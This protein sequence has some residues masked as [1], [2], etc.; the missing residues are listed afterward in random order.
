MNRM[1]FVIMALLPFFFT[2]SA[3]AQPAFSEGFWEITVTMEIQGLD[4]GLSRP[5]VYRRCLT[6]KDP[7]PREPERDQHCRLLRSGLE[8]EALT[9]SVQCGMERGS[10]TGKGRAL[11]YGETLRGV[12]RG[13]IRGEGKKTLSMIQRIEGRRIGDCPEAT[14]DPRRSG[15][16]HR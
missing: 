9:W 11:F 15:P 8:G 6:A 7:I 14:E 2:P 12:M 10:M 5:H 16:P 3:A 13:K 1:F 4:P